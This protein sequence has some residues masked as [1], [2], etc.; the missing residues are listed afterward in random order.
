MKRRGEERSG[1]RVTA[2]YNKTWHESKHRENPVL[3]VLLLMILSL[4]IRGRDCVNFFQGR[5]VGRK[6]KGCGFKTDS[7]GAMQ[8]YR[9]KII[10]LCPH[11][12]TTH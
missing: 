3:H 5:L 6:L 2:P 1:K 11:T 8:V 10:A 7:R 4:A 9:T 12:F